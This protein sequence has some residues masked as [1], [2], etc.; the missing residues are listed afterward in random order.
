M[1]YTVHTLSCQNVTVIQLKKRKMVNQ[2]TKR[3]G[4]GGLPKIT[5]TYTVLSRGIAKVKDGHASISGLRNMI[6]YILTLVVLIF[7]LVK[8]PVLLHIP[9]SP[10]FLWIWPIAL[11]CPLLHPQLTHQD[12]DN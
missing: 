6:S 1:V 8:T 4:F 3:R 5:C 2:G 9:P 12:M 7:K 10:M 11:V